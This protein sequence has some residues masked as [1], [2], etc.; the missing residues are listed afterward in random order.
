MIKGFNQYIK[1]NYGAFSVNVRPIDMLNNA[2]YKNQ[3]YQTSTGQTG[4]I[5]SDNVPQHWGRVSLGSGA[6]PIDGLN[7][8]DDLIKFANEYAED[9][10]IELE[11][12]LDQIEHYICNRIKK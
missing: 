12:V 7:M 8:A 5:R 10:N 6:N 11:E 3:I 2:D 4:Q 1:E 9:N